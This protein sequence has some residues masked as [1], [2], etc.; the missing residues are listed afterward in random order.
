MKH[1][2][3]WLIVFFAV[4]VA[5]C[6]AVDEVKLIPSDAAANDRSGCAVPLDGDT[7]LVGAYYHGGNG[8]HS[9]AVYV[10][11]RNQATWGQ[12]AK[13]TASN[14]EPDDLFGVSVALDGDTALV[15]AFGDDDN[16]SNSGSAYVF[17]RDGT[18]WRQQA[19]L[20]ASD[21]A[22]NDFFGW[23]VA[24]DGDTAFVGA[25]EDDDAGSES[26]SAYM[27]VRDGITWNQQAKLTASDAAAHDLF[28]RAVALDGDTALVGA[29]YDDDNGSNSGSAYVFVRDGATWREQAKLTATDA[30]ADDFFGASVVV[31]EDI[32]LVGAFGA[33]DDNTNSGSAYVFVRDATIWSQQSKLTADK[34]PGNHLF[35]RSVALDGDTALVGAS[36]DDANGSD[37]GSV[38]VFVHDGTAWN[39]QAKLTASDAAAGDLFGWSIALD[40]DTAMV[41]A[42]N[43]DVNGSDSGSAY[44]YL[45]LF[46][47]EDDTA[48]ALARAPVAEGNEPPMFTL[49]GDVTVD[50]DFS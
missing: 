42:S 46:A 29:Y 3:I 27:F 19:K 40:G 49:S 10:F 30:A 7:A 32:V 2:N 11:A 15:G 39:Q 34:A 1:V 44:I 16:G 43:D 36:N 23:S 33:Y 5:V 47:S 35:G 38:Y 26:G 45:N 31:D 28:G 9:G 13:L 18:I 48:I 4:K 20:T 8:L 22:T 21:G 37:S 25:H 14:G 12:Q 6:H 24:L 50:E 17:V 41:G